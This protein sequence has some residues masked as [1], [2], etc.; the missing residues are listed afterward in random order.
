MDTLK[1]PSGP[2]I[3][4]AVCKLID[5]DAD[6]IAWLNGANDEGKIYTKDIGA[7]FFRGPVH[8]MCI[9]VGID[10]VM[11]RKTY[12]SGCNTYDVGFTV[13]VF[14][15]GG[16]DALP[17][18]LMGYI[19]EAIKGKSKAMAVAGSR[20]IFVRDIR[21]LGRTGMQPTWGGRGLEFTL[22]MWRIASRFMA[23]AKYV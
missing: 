3:R 13:N 21:F 15:A 9:R 16:S 23:I 7:Y 1:P 14:S 6:V 22:D 20:T 11:P 10:E 19:E 12:E 2:D 8:D 17:S 5:D 4:A 18:D